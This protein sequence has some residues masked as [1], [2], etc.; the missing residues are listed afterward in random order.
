M[1]SKATRRG[2]LPSDLMTQPLVTRPGYGEGHPALPTAASTKPSKSQ[3]DYAKHLLKQVGGEE[4]DW[5]SLDSTAVSSLI[6]GLKKKRGKPVWYGNGQFSHWDKKADLEFPLA[7]AELP[8]GGPSDRGLPL[9]SGIPGYKTFSK[10]EDD[11]RTPESK[12]EPIKRVDGPDNLTKDRD[13]VDTR[14]DNARIGPPSLTDTGPWDSSPKTPYPYRDDKPNTHNASADMVAGYWILET[15]PERFLPAGCRTAAIAEEIEERLNP[16]V[17]RRSQQCRATLR[18]ADISNLRW[19]FSVDCGHGAKVVKVKADRVGNALKFSKLDLHVACSCPA[20][21]WQGPEYHAK[22]N[23]YQDP[24]TRLQGTASAPDIRDPHRVNKVC[25][26]VAA[27]L[28]LT[29]DWEIPKRPAKTAGLVCACNV[30]EATRALS[31]G[32]EGYQ[33]PYLKGLYVRAVGA[34]EGEALLQVR[35][36]GET[37]GSRWVHAEDLATALARLGWTG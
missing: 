9:D 21:R 35:R 29:R 17:R 26:H 34:P 37:W 18:R 25:K 10:P 4:P 15:A 13:R 31:S 36:D 2:K 12:D 8:T 11:I 30:C 19:M 5:D 24:K 20:W 6:D 7:T 33:A 1:P 27:V 32:P 23:D 22:S 14:E 16:A 3:I 28:H